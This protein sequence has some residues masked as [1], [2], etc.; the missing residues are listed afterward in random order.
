MHYFRVSRQPYCAVHSGGYMKTVCLCLLVMTILLGIVAYDLHFT[1]VALEKVS[2]DIRDD[3]Q[4]NEAVR[5]LIKDN[6]Q[7]LVK[8]AIRF[9]EFARRAK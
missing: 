1:R 7:Q 8:E 3:W 6:S 2:N 5:T 9:R 4:R